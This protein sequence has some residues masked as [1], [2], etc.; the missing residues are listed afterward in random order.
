VWNNAI[1][2]NAGYLLLISMIIATAQL[3]TFA[4]TC[5]FL[6]KITPT[7]RAAFYQS[8]AFAALNLSVVTARLTSGSTFDKVPM[9]HSCLC[10]LIAW[11]IG[12]IWLAYEYKVLSPK[13]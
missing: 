4:L 8:L 3:V 12:M 9:M 7:N 13:T 1:T 5:S 11:S 10:L 2:V 6:S